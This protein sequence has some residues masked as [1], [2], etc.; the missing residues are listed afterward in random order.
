M[1][2]ILILILSNLVINIY[3]NDT[4]LKVKV[5]SITFLNK[6]G[7]EFIKFLTNIVNKSMDKNNVNVDYINCL[8]IKSVD[9]LIDT[10]IHN[11]NVYLIFNYLINLISNQVYPY[12]SD[13]LPNINYL[14]RESEKNRLIIK[15]KIKLNL[16]YMLIVFMKGKI[17]GRKKY[18]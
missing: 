14:N 13:V 18:K 1:I 6:K 15:S 17:N 5:F 12:I 16:I 7:D 8:D 9:I 4:S 10:K 3:V 11:F 2:I